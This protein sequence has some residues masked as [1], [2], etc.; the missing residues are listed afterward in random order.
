MA[1]L[2]EYQRK[3]DFRKTAEPSG[4]G[5]TRKSK[6]VGGLYVIQKHAATRLHYDFR[7]E[8]NGV[9]WSWAVTRGPSLDPSE[10]RLAV[11]VEDHPLDYGDFEGTIP[12]GEYGGGAV[13][14]WDNGEWIPEGDPEAGMKKG[15]I[16]FE[17]KGNKLNGRWHL[18][19]LKPRRGEKRDNWLL[20]KSDDSAA[21]RSGDILEEAP[22]SVK[23]GLTIDEIGKNGKVDVWHPKSTAGKSSGPKGRSQKAPRPGKQATMPDFVPPCLATLQTAPPTGGE[24]LHEV[25]FDGYRIQAHLSGGRPKLLTRKG[26]DWSDRFGKAIADALASLD[27]ENAILDGEIVVLADNGVSSFSALQAALSGRQTEKLI[28]YVFDMLFL[29]GMDV[30]GEPLA[31]RKERLRDL[32]KPLGEQGPVRYSEHFTEPGKTMLA[33]ACRMGLEG[34]VSKRA[35]AAYH[36]GRGHDWIKSRCTQR[37]EFVIAGY[38]PSDKTGRGLRSLIVGYY[39]GG[40]LKSA[41]HVGTGFSAKAGVDLK[42][43][44]DRLKRK[45]SPLTGPGSKEKQAIWVDPNLVAEVEFRSWTADRILRHASFQGL[46]EDKPS[47]D[48]VIEEPEDT[49]KAGAKSAKK[50]DVSKRASAKKGARTSVTLTH[51]DKLLWPE[52]GI[53]K[54][55]LLDYY[56]EVWPLM[57]QFVIDRPLALVRAPDGVG[58]PRFFQKHASPGMHEKILRMA[59]PKDGEELL[60]IEDFDG[61]TA[62]VQNG[63]VEIHIWGSKIGTIEKPDQIIFDLDPD[64]GLDVA[65]VREATLDVHSRLDELDMPNFVKTSGG[66]GF[67]VVVPLKPKADWERVKTFAHDFA[68]AMEQASP[69]RY[70]ATLSKKARAGRIF[71]DYLRNGRGSTTVVPYSSRGKPNATVSMPVDWKA[72]EGNVGPGDYTI[73]DA[74]GRTKVEKADIWRDFFKEGYTLR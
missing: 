7:L 72:L 56:E 8:H 69:K 33:H 29:D 63:V 6:S 11:H 40:E 32:L 5:K 73:G 16:D 62:L 31:D 68:R 20:I 28:Y 38:L 9:L 60:Y 51:P 53:T 58:G 34:V 54:Q 57:E 49:A 37:Q 26:L 52:A 27:C 30:S 25:K 1:G 47:K 10:K 23:S 18:V 35:D 59:D 50:K 67:H 48:V 17:L 21:S 65:A 43:K 24:W 14:V 19:R 12:K 41:G 36:S 13:I 64:E 15:H 44:L 61:L 39:E 74:S 46:R 22:Q 42:K 3:R 70:T 2:Q 66:K 45:T 55:V 71:I 4:K